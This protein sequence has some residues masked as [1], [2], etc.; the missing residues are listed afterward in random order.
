MAQAPRV[1]PPAADPLGEA[2]HLLRLT[3]ALYC[4]SELTAPW[5]ID[6]PPIEGCM[7][8]H[9]VMAGRCWLKIEGEEP[10]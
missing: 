5:G 6:L 7:M 1:L 10:H 9:L 8:F 2:L 3:G 4:R